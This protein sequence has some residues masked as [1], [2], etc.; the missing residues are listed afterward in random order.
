MA[1]NLHKTRESLGDLGCNNNTVTN[2]CYCTE[3]GNKE[4]MR[5]KQL[6]TLPHDNSTAL[7]IQECIS[8]ERR[9]VARSSLECKRFYADF[10]K[11]LDQG[12]QNWVTSLCKAQYNQKYEKFVVAI[13]KPSYHYYVLLAIQ[14]NP[15]NPRNYHLFIKKVTCCYQL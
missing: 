2:P 14:S 9:K 1:L 6:L 11:A 10:I 7:S 3:Y 15:R 8:Q 5:S 4:P 13:C 12:L